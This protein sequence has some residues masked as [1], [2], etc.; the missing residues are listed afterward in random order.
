M[1][2]LHVTPYYWPAVRYGGPVFSVAGLCRALAERGHT[3]EV[4]T[5][6]VDGKENSRV[7]LEK[8]M[9]VDGVQVTYFPSSLLRRLFWSP[10]MQQALEQNI[11]QFDLVHLHTCFV[12]P[13]YAAAMAA[14]QAGVP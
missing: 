8:P 5:T 7:E 4:Y 3:V 6:A 12:W 10:S 1:N 13:V 9:D 2:I 14:Q 11:C